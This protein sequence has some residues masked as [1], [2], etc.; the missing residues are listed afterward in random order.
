[1]WRFAGS[2]R[3]RLVRHANRPGSCGR[4]GCRCSHRRSRQRWSARRSNRRSCWSRDRRLDW[5]RDPGRSGSRIRS[6][7]VGRLSVRDTRR[8]TRNVSQSLHR[9]HLRFARSSTGRIDPRRRYR[10]VVPKA[11]TDYF[12]ALIPRPRDQRV[13]FCRASTSA[14]ASSVIFTS[15][16]HSR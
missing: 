10:P 7:T 11:V 6:A 4:S 14:L 8:W 13:F 1:L 2:A 15:S 16:G 12:N 3:S 9:T 5:P